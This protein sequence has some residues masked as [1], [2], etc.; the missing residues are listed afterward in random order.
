VLQLIFHHQSPL[1]ISKESYLSHECYIMKFD[2]DALSILGHP[3]ILPDLMPHGLLTLGNYAMLPKSKSPHA[4]L[5]ATAPYYVWYLP[6]SKS[7]AATMKTSLIQH[8][9]T[10][11]NVVHFPSSNEHFVWALPQTISINDFM[12]MLRDVGIDQVY[13]TSFGMKSSVFWGLDVMRDVQQADPDA[14]ISFDFAGEFGVNECPDGA[15]LSQDHKY[16]TLMRMNP[17]ELAVSGFHG[18]SVHFMMFPQIQAQIN[19]FARVPCFGSVSMDRMQVPDNIQEMRLAAPTKMKA[20]CT[21]HHLQKQL[22]RD[23]FKFTTFKT[24]KNRVKKLREMVELLS[25]ADPKLRIECTFTVTNKQSLEL[26]EFYKNTVKKLLSTLTTMFL[27]VEYVRAE[28]SRVLDYMEWEGQTLSLQVVHRRND[29]KLDEYQKAF[30]TI[31]LMFCG[32]ASA[33]GNHIFVRNYKNY[34]NCDAPIDALIVDMWHFFGLNFELDLEKITRNIESVRDLNGYPTR[35][36][37]QLPSQRYSAAGDLTFDTM[38]EQLILFARFPSLQFQSPYDEFMWRA[39]H[40]EG[41]FFQAGPLLFADHEDFSEDGGPMFDK[42]DS[43]AEELDDNC[44]LTK[45]LDIQ[46]AK[47]RTDES[48]TKFR[49]NYARGQKF[50]ERDTQSEIIEHVQSLLA[51]GHP[52]V[53]TKDWPRI[54]AI[55]VQCEACKLLFSPKDCI[56]RSVS[57]IVIKFEDDD[58]V[59]IERSGIC[60]DCDCDGDYVE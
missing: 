34:T 48:L 20:Y 7:S 8:L 32:L 14:E 53:T 52:R 6:E 31:M 49:L 16:I 28:I 55:K 42:S 58:V 26:S 9:S 25:T 23:W 13:C 51:S 22:L 60:T 38:E 2:I 30:V 3:D 12:S 5:L 43:S 11:R 10:V 44:L 21:F 29:Q 57:G 36:P 54:L 15:G 24:V 1:I 41:I 17:E 4:L 46:V 59:S 50:A 47:S 39:L 35:L 37:V 19:H 27:P 18:R 56:K 45:W 33:G 40:D